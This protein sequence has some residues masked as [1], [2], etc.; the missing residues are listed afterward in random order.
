ME[1]D[2]NKVICIDVMKYNNETLHE[3]AAYLGWDGKALCYNKEHGIKK[4]Y[5]SP[6]ITE[7]TGFL[8]GHNVVAI[9][10]TSNPKVDTEGDVTKHNLKLNLPFTTREIK[11]LMQIKPFDF[12]AFRKKKNI[13]A[14]ELRRLNKNE[15]TSAEKSNRSISEKPQKQSG[16]SKVGREVNKPA[17]LNLDTILD[18]ISKLG[19]D[20]LSKPERDFLD[21]FSRS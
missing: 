20:A 3:F 12:I 2:L 17:K 11:K 10:F 21:R 7:E 8:G 9:E 19:L 6:E 15:K 16:S 4:Y 14:A 13:E 1:I 18:K 5:I